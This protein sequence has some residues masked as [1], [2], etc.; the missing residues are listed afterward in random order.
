MNVEAPPRPALEP[1]APC[2]LKALRAIDLTQQPDARALWRGPAPGGRAGSPAIELPRPGFVS[3]M[4]FWLAEVQDV[5][6]EATV[7]PHIIRF[8]A[9]SPAA[10][11]AAQ[12]SRPA[13]APAGPR[14]RPDQTVRLKP[15]HVGDGELVLKLSTA[16]V[17]VI[18]TE[19]AWK[20]LAEP[21]LLAVGLYW[22]F[23]AIEDEIDRLTEQAHADL[24]HA[25][26]PA[27]PAW[28]R[29]RELIA[30]ARA[31]RDLLLDL[32]HFQGPLTDPYPYCSTERSA[33]AFEGLA[34]KLHFEE[35]CE[36]IDERAEAIEDTYEA[37]TEKFM[38]FRHFVYEATLEILIVV[39]LLG[40]LG[41]ALWEQLS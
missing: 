11:Q 8:E 19:A 25:T 28:K 17:R 26:M 27:G 1:G 5:V 22:R 40:E 35:W 18:T 33:Q 12:E 6:A 39:I 23:L 24:D 36:R 13:A 34:E 7:S 20:A 30:N 38:E 29:R 31:V 16:G 21:V 3:P 32:P 41:V 9:H 2:T 37:A 15:P 4:G 10:V 14:R